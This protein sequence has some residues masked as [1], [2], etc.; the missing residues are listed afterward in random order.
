MQNWHP[1]SWQNYPCRQTVHYPELKALDNVV[2]QLSYL[3]PLVNPHEIQ[4]LK[5]HIAQ[6]ARGKSFLLQGGDCAERFVDCDAVAI[7][8]KLKIIFQMSLILMHRIHKPVIHLGRMAG[9]YAKPRT[10]ELEVQG[11]IAL[12]VY[13][14][15][16]VNKPDFNLLARTPDPKLML[17]GYYHAALTINYVR[18]LLESGF[19]DLQHPEQWALDFAEA[20]PL[21][22][23][24]QTMASA[25]SQTLELLKALQGLHADQL[26]QSNF[27]T[28]HEAL[29]LYYEQ[30]QT[31]LGDDNRWYACST[32]FPWIGMR[33]GQ[34]DGAHV[35]FARG[36]ANP[37]GVKIGP[38]A[39]PDWLMSLVELLN[40]DNEPGRLT[41]ITRF[42][43]EQIETALPPLIEAVTETGIEVLWSCD[44]MHGNTEV[45]PT[46]IKTRRFDD[47]L[48]ELEQASYIHQSMDS[49]L[50]GVHFELTGENV[51]E[52]IGGSQGLTEA[53]LNRDYQSLVDPRLNYEQALE[54]AMHLAQLL[55]QNQQVRSV[56]GSKPSFQGEELMLP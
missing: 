21:A 24:Y 22:A 45:T 1:R 18:T 23:D 3:P 48:Y 2:E 16:L 26:K 10:C 42:G 32:H 53:D 5:Q 25:M 30:A 11:E 14:G 41:L 15:D 52:C 51:T 35:E 50:G 9:Q 39:S 46:G 19:A 7:S 6:A 29:N 12:P 36:I 28:S 31:Q 56:D 47:I 33:T 43:A 34:L 4:Q 38:D 37:I 49:H 44:P 13:R 55:K 27:Y 20:S 8:N 17:Q 40:P 54:M